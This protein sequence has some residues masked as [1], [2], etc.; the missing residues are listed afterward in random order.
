MQHSS[1]PPNNSLGVRRMGVMRLLE[2]FLEDTMAEDFEGK[3]TKDEFFKK[4]LE[5]KNRDYDFEYLKIT[6]LIITICMKRIMRLKGIQ[7]PY[8]QFGRIIIDGKKVRKRFWCG[9]RWKTSA[10]VQAAQD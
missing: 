10:E 5:Y 1:E 8:E 7:P 2:L 6:P 9:F 3:V 4:I